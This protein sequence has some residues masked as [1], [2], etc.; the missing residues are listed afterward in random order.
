MFD[1][2]VG[3]PPSRRQVFLQKLPTVQQ[4]GVAALFVFI[5]SGKFDSDGMWVQ[6]FEQI[7]WGQW[8]RY[9]TGVMQAGGGILVLFRRTL[10]LGTASIAATMI[11]AAITDVVVMKAPVFIMIPLLLLTVVLATWATARAR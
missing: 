8:F 7:G 4:V 6:L 2:L 9:L 5:G 10:T 3:E 11:G 1:T